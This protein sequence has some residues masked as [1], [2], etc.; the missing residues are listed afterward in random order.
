MNTPPPR[1]PGVDAEFEPLGNGDASETQPPTDQPWLKFEI[2]G[3]RAL[4]HSAAPTLVFKL[5]IEDRS[6]RDIFAAAL[7]LQIMFEPVKR[8]YDDST[9]ERLAE[10]FGEPGRWGTTAR[11]LMWTTESVLVSDFKDR[12]SVDVPVLCNYDLE[13]AA[14]RY[15]SELPDGEVPLVIH[16][17]GSVYYAEPDGRLQIVQIPWDTVAEYRMPVSAWRQMIEL[18]YPFRTWVPLSS[19]TLDRL[20][21]TK[22]ARGAH[23]Y[24]DTIAGLIDATP[25]DEE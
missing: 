24:D 7:T 17:N 20:R 14:T 6:G 18:H 10:L 25:E 1:P 11:Q 2:G 15:F 21:K 16:F 5:D 12:T 19:E 4:E 9:R 22:I 8:G 23:T 13:L 3:V